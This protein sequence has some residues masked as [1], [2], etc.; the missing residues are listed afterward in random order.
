[1]PR[2]CTER[3]ALVTKDVQSPSV[4]GIPYNTMPPKAK[5]KQKSRKPTK[6]RAARPRSIN[7]A[8]VAIG[9]SFGN[10]GYTISG[11][12]PTGVTVRGKEV[13]GPVTAFA[14][15]S[16]RPG[17][18][19]DSNPACWTNSRLSLIAKT[20]EKYCFT[21][22]TIR[23]IS[24]AASTVGGTVAV[25]VETDPAEKLSLSLPVI[26]NMQYS[27]IGPTWQNLSVP[28]KT[29]KDDKSVYFCSVAGSTERRE[30]T[31]FLV[32][33]STYGVTVPA[34]APNIDVGWLEIEY[35]VKF[36][37]QELEMG[38]GGVQFIPEDYQ[39][40]TATAGGTVSLSFTNM[41][42]GT[43]VAEM[44]IVEPVGA[45]ADERTVHFGTGTS[46]TMELVPGIAIY[47]AWTGGVWA[48]YATLAAA[49]VLGA[50]LQWK[51][52]RNQ[53]NFRGYLRPLH[54]RFDQ[55]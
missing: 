45:T 11:G 51:N 29:D 20:Y 40:N 35:E 55:Y 12:G 7:V 54:D 50:A 15:G 53:Q 37:Y 49:R 4:S 38:S 47:V 1:M 13:L 44:R 21:R 33:A 26:S 46:N 43:K 39:V 24:S 14:T 36:M 10:S 18:V 23:F 3:P 16:G 22:A 30:N 42:V 17:A 48:A 32:A 25:Y 8:P 2:D 6:K 9:T 19:F 41:P 28:F 34:P 5:N 27:R 31:Q 52:A